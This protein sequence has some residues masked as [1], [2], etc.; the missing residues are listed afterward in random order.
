M[1]SHFHMV[2]VCIMPKQSE[3]RIFTHYERIVNVECVFVCVHRHAKGNIHQQKPIKTN[4]T[5]RVYYIY[6]ENKAIL[7]LKVRKKVEPDKYTKR[8]MLNERK[9]SQHKYCSASAIC[10]SLSLSLPLVRS[11]FLHCDGVLVLC[12]ISSHI[13][14]LSIFHPKTIIHQLICGN[15][16]E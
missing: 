3:V 6:N 11:R 13:Y 9:S 5:L 2:C 15:F 4:K 12:F 16:V 8:T 1:C 10:L 7:E 14:L